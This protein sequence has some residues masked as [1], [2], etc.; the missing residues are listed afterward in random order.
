MKQGLDGERALIGFCGAPWTVA[1]YMVAGRGTREQAPARQ[2]AY[3]DEAG[4]AQL[5][6]LIVAASIEYLG[7]QIE[8]G[9]EAVQLF[10]S[11][12]GTLPDDQFEKW[13]IEPCAR[14][15]TAIKAKYPDVP[16]IGFPRAAGPMSEAFAAHTGI[17]AIGCDTSLP[18]AWIKARLQPKLAVQGNLDPL[19]LEAGGDAME[20]RIGAILKELRGGPFV[21]NLGHGIVPSTPPEH[22]ARLV[23]IVRGG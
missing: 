19:V 3:R 2:W 16:V 12:A 10:D 8:A 9:A 5:I 22:V 20:R 17:D 7:G 11:W 6:D 4:F 14:I 23:E 1:T 21:F 15:V 18:L 13:S